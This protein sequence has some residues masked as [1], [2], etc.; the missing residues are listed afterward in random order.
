M[1]FEPP[2]PSRPGAFCPWD[3]SCFSAAAPENQEFPINYAA[4]TPKQKLVSSRVAAL[5]CGSNVRSD[6]YGSVETRVMEAPF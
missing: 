4:I 2:D 6:V 1:V 5:M 3:V